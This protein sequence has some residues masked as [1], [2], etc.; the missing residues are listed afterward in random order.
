MTAD[1]TASTDCQQHPKTPSDLKEACCHSGRSPKP[2]M[3]G[4]SS[5]VFQAAS[6]LYGVVKMYAAFHHEHYN[7]FVGK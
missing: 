5:W 6:E 2:E 7:A 1:F 3:E 4:L